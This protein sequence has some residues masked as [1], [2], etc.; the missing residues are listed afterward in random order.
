MTM[1]H[2]ERIVAAGRKQ[3]TDKLPFGARIDVWYN[4][5]FAHGTLPEK[6]KDKNIVE[7]CRDQGAGSQ[8]RLYRTW[9]VD[10]TNLEAKVTENPPRKT[11]EWRTPLGNVSMTTIFTPQEGPWIAYEL[12][13]PFKKKEDY[14]VIEYILQNTRLTPDYTEYNRLEKIAGN[15]GIV[16][17]GMASYSPMQQIMRYWIGFERFFYELHDN[18]AQ[19]ERLFELEK[20]LAKQKVEI[21]SKLPLEMIGVC[22][23][24]SD[25][26]HTPIFMKY[27]VPWL[28]ETSDYFHSVGKLTHVHADGEMKRLI[29]YFTKTH[30]DIAEAWSPIPMTSVT[31]AELRK[32]WGDKVTIWGGIPAT[33]FGPQ[34]SDAEF[35]AYIKNLFKE[36][37]PGY[38]FIVGM[39]DNLPF[40]GKIERVGRVAELIE[41]YGKLPIEM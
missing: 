14:P 7:I 2:R 32:A 26:F 40:D 39:G 41:K 4:Y 8:M 24:W 20:E 28:K 25:E 38:N 12:D 6:Y 27:F 36:I 13:H 11:T 16:M 10:Y 15:D 17:T 35:D 18:G 31:T 5:H 22:S 9:K 1:T 30:V 29:P 3:K 33:L 23:N 37:A 34:Y 21:L 19:V